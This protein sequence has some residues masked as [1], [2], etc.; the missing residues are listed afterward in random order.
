MRGGEGQRAKTDRDRLTRADKGRSRRVRGSRQVR[1]NRAD[2]LTLHRSVKVDGRACKAIDR[3][4]SSTAPRSRARCNDETDLGN[5]PGSSLPGRWCRSTSPGKCPARLQ[6][7]PP[8]RRCRRIGLCRRRRRCCNPPVDGQLPRS[9]PQLHGRETGGAE[10]TE[11]IRVRASL[12]RDFSWSVS[13][14]SG[15]R[16]RRRDLTYKQLDLWRPSYPP[17][18]P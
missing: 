3:T 13:W 10:E 17:R 14:T 9:V 6:R 4:I 5:S 11:L 2:E 15:S 12:R 16:A 1:C 7:P 8:S 18:Q